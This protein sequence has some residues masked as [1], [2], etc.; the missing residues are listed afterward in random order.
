MELLKKT[1]L[2]SLMVSLSACGL[3][4]EKAAVYYLSKAEKIIS[5]KSA[6]PADIEEAYGFIDKALSK[7]PDSERA[8]ALLE[9]LSENAYK[10]GFERGGE[11]ETAILKK[12]V[13]ASADNWQ[14][15]MALITVLGER[16]DVPSIRELSLLLETRSSSGTVAESAISPRQAGV[17]PSALYNSRLL[18]LSCYSALASWLEA[19]GFLA[20]NKDAERLE[21]NASHYVAV[22]EKIKALKTGLEKEEAESPELKKNAPPNILSSAEITSAD[23]LKNSAEAEKI[24]NTVDQ[25]AR[26]AGFKKALELTVE[27]NKALVNKDYPRARA[28]YQGALGNYPDFIDARKQQVEADFQEGASLAIVNENRPAARALLLKAYQG[29]SQVIAA[30]LEKGNRMPFVGADKFM[31]EIYALR[32]AVISAFGAVGKPDP[33]RKARM[34]KDLKEALDSAVKFNPDNRIARELLERYAKEGF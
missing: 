3:A 25:L 12:T 21:R 31:S 22:I 1:F 26:D 18:L 30:G 27:G 33:R 7:A 24:K 32:A 14:A 13:K 5:E 16:G 2:I 15:A 9:E 29:S 34:E 4:R 10:S 20:L 19:D 28:F 11:F 6:A 8:L 17:T 23:A